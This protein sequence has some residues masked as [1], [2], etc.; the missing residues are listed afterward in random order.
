MPEALFCPHPA[1]AWNIW[2]L[3]SNVLISF[4]LNFSLL[5]SYLFLF[6]YSACDSLCTCVCFNYESA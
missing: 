2:Q 6:S 3:Y 4:E 1:P 5:L